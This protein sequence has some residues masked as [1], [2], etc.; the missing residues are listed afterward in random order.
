[1]DIL[2]SRS[3]KSLAAQLKKQ[4]VEDDEEDVEALSG[5]TTARAGR[6]S[7]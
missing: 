4:A 2:S 5:A 7:V 1:M 6:A 3:N